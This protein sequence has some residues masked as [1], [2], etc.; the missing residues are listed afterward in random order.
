MLTCLRGELTVAQSLYAQLFYALLLFFI[1]LPRDTSSSERLGIS[2]ERL[3]ISW[4]RLTKSWERDR[5][6]P[7][8]F[9]KKCFEK[10]KTSALIK[11]VHVTSVPP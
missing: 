9:K 5:K 6:R 4:K 2:W 8:Q 7:V 1:S 11:V 10:K 3:S